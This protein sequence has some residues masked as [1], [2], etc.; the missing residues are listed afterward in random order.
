MNQQQIIELLEA[1]KNERGIKNWHKLSETGGLKTF[2]IGLTQ[3][4]KLAKKIGKNHDL[5]MALWQSDYYDIKVIS[6]LIDEPKKITREQAEKQVDELNAGMLRHVF[7]SCD[8]TLPKTAFAF[9]LCNDWINS[10]DTTRRNCGYGLLYELSKNKRHP[11]LT[12]NFFLETIKQIDETI[13]SED[14]KVRMSMAGAL[15]GIGKRNKTLNSACIKVAKRTGSIDYND[16]GS[17]CEP[18]DIMKHLTSDYLKQKF[19]A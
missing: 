19:S 3:L 10:Q 2:G 9:E 12:D 18:I 13:D 7:S 17:K 15:I 5:S 11:A 1:Q 6:L 16:S 4:R 8:A 14:N